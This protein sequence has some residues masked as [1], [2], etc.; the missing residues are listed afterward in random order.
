[1]NLDSLLTNELRLSEYQKRALNKIGLKTAKDLLWH[2]PS[3]YEE[4]APTSSIADISEGEKATICGK[5]LEIKMEKTW[6]KKLIIAEAVLSD[7]TGEINLVWF[8]QPYIAH[9][10]KIGDAIAASGKIQKNKKG[11][12]IANPTYEKI[13]PDELSQIKGLIP[14][15]PETRGL[16]SRWFR[17]AIKK[18]LKKS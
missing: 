10:L 3:R 5:I 14:I 13:N 17:F 8:H 12:Y 15:Y 7:G 16:S 1:M 18:I 2:F 6:R 9:Y 11:S 4:F